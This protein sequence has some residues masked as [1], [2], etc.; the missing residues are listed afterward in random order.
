[1]IA[2][3]NGDAHLKNWS[4]IYLDGRTPTLS[5]AYDLVSTFTYISK[6]ETLALNL[7]G[8]KDFDSVS[9]ETFRRM[10]R[11]I[12]LESDRLIDET[13]RQTVDALQ[14]SWSKLEADL[15]VRSD[16]TRAIRNRLSALP[17]MT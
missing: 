13:V 7:G 12:G 17:L 2:M 15:P 16:V 4:L 10:A 3:G 1:M 8:S 6:K 5:P 9:L 14:T 11:K